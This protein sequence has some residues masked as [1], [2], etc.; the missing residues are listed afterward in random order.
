MSELKIGDRVRIVSVPDLAEA[1]GVKISIGMTGTV[2]RI[3]GNLVGVEFDDYMGGHSGFWEGKDGY[4]WHVLH[5]R[6]EKI[7]ETDTEEETKTEPFI[8]ECGED[9]FFLE[10]GRST[11]TDDSIDYGR[12][13]LGGV[14]RNEKE[15]LE[16]KDKLLEK[17]EKLRKGEQI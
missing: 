15:A 10:V 16:N 3:S 9:Y 6:L 13:A 14:Y 12:L 1:E 5:E 7:E 17:L 8:P 2:K 4:C 11:W